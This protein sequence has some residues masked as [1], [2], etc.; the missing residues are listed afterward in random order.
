MINNKDQEQLLKLICK[1]IK[2]DITCYALGGTAMMFFGYKNTTKDIDLVFLSE[3]DMNAFIEAI[4]SLN[5]S[6]KSL[7]DIYSKDKIKIKSKPKIFSRGDE[8]FDLFLNNI[9][10]FS[11]DESIDEYIEQKHEFIE[12]NRLIIKIL[13]KEFII[14]LKTVTN[15]EKDFEDILS[16]IKK[17][18]EIDWDL[19]IKEAIKR[20]KDNNWI[21]I[22]LE[23]MMTKLKEHIFIPSKYF[24][25]L[26]NVLD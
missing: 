19:L 26:Y 22:D 4:K 7:V 21:I 12:K 18:P 24:D 20:K 2:K 16:I 8:R 10:G 17:T 1:N 13:P 3:K 5:Y 14:L 11:F 6:E 9:F 15:R 23:E 25:M